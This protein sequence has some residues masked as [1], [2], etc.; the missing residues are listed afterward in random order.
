MKQLRVSVCGCSLADNIYTNVDFHSPALAPFLSRRDGD[1]GIAP[2][3]LVFAEDLE[4][5]S[6]R[7]YQQIRMAFSPSG[8]PTARN[9]GGP[10]IVGAINAA[11]ILHDRR[12]VFSFFGLMGDDSTGDFLHSMVAKTPIDATH[13][14]RVHGNTPC[15]DVLSDPRYHDGKGER[16]FV[17]RVGIAG[18]LGPEDLTGDFFDSDVL[19]FAATAL[20]PRLHD[21]LTSLLKKAKTMGRFTVVSTVFDFRN[22]KKDPAAPWPL[23]ENS[24]ESYRNIDLFIVD[25]EE[26][27]RLSGTKSISE[28]ADFLIRSGVAAFFITAGSKNFYV[29]SNGS[30]FEPCPLTSLPVSSLVDEDLAAHPELRGDTTGCGDNFAGGVVASFVRQLSEMVKPGT[31][32]LQ[33]AAAW[34]AASGGT[35]CFCVGGTY[36]EHSPGEKY[37]RMKRY[38]AAYPEQL[39]TSNQH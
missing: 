25:Q 3:K 10:A 11:Q 37:D 35:A 19:W 26:A 28:A 7:E 13:Y 22:E 33:D 32:S 8:E 39:E 15:T 5:F 23:G 20:V 38:V 14:L 4:V 6:R 16:S 12:V 31:L 17:N 21:H 9:L 24:A 27:E 2:G 29:W 1:G 34:A 30:V 18:Q 36:I